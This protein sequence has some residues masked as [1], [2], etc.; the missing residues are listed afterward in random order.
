MPIQPNILLM[1][2]D[3]LNASV[4]GCY[5]GPV[6]TPNLDRLTREGILFDQAICPYPVCSPTRA[7]IVTGLYPHTHGITHNI[8]KRDYPAIGAPDTEEGIKTDDVTT[9]KLLHAAGYQTHHYGKWHLLDDDLPYYTDMFTEHGAYVQEMADTFA[10]VREQPASQWMNWYDWALP[11]E[12]APPLAEAVAALGDRWSGGMYTDFI[13]KMGRLR[14]PAEQSFDVRVADHTVERLR[15]LDERPFMLTCSFNTPHDPNVVPSPYYESVSPDDIE[16]PATFDTREPRVETHWSRLIISELGEAAARE[17]LRIYYASCMLV[18]EQVG[19]VLNALD[20]SG[21][22]NDTIVIFTADHGD[23]A[24]NHGMVWKSSDNFYED[25][26]RVPLIMR[27]PRR[28]PPGPS[29]LHFS[30]T[31]LMPTLLALTGQPAQAHV[32][33]TDLSPYLLGQTDPAQAPSHTFCERVPAGPEGRRIV[34]P[35]TPG[36]FMIRGQGW[37]YVRYH[38]GDQWLFDLD[39]DPLEERNLAADPERQGRRDAMSGLLDDWLRETGFPG[40]Q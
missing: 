28:L 33:G 19:R 39:N 13:T 36:S 2:C 35:G 8:N 37:K 29:S 15:S 25:L 38:D 34:N 17:F 14:L 11:V 40:S 1:M 22:A 12:V 21:R 30:T 10:G 24:G 26:V 5:G 4:L 18:D 3:Q 31:G 27:Y 23:M 6:P 7:S 32:Q 16:L 9:E 20:V